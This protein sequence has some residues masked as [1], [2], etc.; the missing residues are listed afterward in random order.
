MSPTE[1]DLA[2]V[3]R[4]YFMNE[5]YA[6]ISDSLAVPGRHNCRYDFFSAV[7]D[8][9]LR[10]LSDPEVQKLWNAAELECFH[11]LVAERKL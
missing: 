11:Y 8:W 3:L 5:D 6:S 2:L 4:A 1:A 9:S 10:Y 7:R